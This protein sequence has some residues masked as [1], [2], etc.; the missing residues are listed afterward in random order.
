MKSEIDINCDLGEEEDR[1]LQ[2][3]YSEIFKH[4]SSCNVACGMHGG[5]PLFIES[6][7]SEAIENRV[8]IGA[9]PSYP[10]IPGFGRRHIKMDPDELKSSLKYQIAAIK[11][12]TESLGGSVRYVK[13]HGALYNTVAD[14]LME[15]KVLIEAMKEIDKKLALMGLAGS[16]LAAFAEENGVRFIREGFADRRYNLAGRL[17]SREEPGAVISDPE[18]ASEQV[19]SMVSGGKIKPVEKSLVSTDIDTVCIH[20][21]NPNVIMILEQIR[22]KLKLENIKIKPVSI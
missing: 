17:L 3:G 21:D 11:G 4:I 1:S 12:L 5:K 13:P 19:I 6:T 18:E 2:R 20:G 14:N 10:D 15:A 9:H 22:E 7:I 8:Q 16:P